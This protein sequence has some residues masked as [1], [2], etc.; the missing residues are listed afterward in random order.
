MDIPKYQIFVS[1]TYEDLKEERAGIVRAI[2]EMGHIPV[3]MEMFSAG[4]EDQWQVI[5]RTI[6]DCD[7]YVVLLA[8]RYGSMDGG[9]SYT[10]K[11]YDFAVK[12]NIPVLGFIINADAAWPNDRQD[13]CPDKLGKLGAFKDKAKERAV[14]FWSSADELIGKCAISLMKAFSLTPRPGWIKATNQMS[15]E[16][17]GELSRLSAENANLRK[18]LEREESQDEGKELASEREIHQIL[19]D[20]STGL[21][22]YYKDSKGWE[23]EGEIPL[24]TVFLTVAPKLQVE[25]EKVELAFTLAFHRRKDHDRALRT[26]WPYP[27]NAI[28]AHLADFQALGLVQPSAIRHP[29]KDNGEYWTLTGLGK[30]VFHSIRRESLLSRAQKTR[31]A[32][33]A[34]EISDLLE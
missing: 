15:P 28:E 10:E 18:R 5:A 27:S 1:S 22:I 12:N 29:V 21:S 11:E 33:Q 20:T 32:R 14:Q 26:G 24:R 8:K 19:A 30:K 16:A 4:D 3:G 23:E 17:A 2:L 34:E 25:G 6:S 9:I 31:A 13:T 7:Y